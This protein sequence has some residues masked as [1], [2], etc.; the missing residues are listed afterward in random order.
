MSR[1]L[2][3][4]IIPV[5][6]EEPN[7]NNCLL[8]LQRLKSE[9]LHNKYEFEYIFTDNNS[10]DGSRQTLHEACM[11]DPSVKYIRF[12]TNVGYQLSILTGYINANGAAMLQ[13]DC[14]MQDPIE[15]AAEFIQL[16]S[17]GY[18]VVYGVRSS[19]REGTVITHCRRAFYRVLNVLS[20]VQIPIDAG[21]FRLLDREVCQRLKY[22]KD[23]DP[24]IRGIIASFGYRQVGVP[25][26]R[27]ARREGTSK[28]PL[29][30]LYKL[31]MHGLINH[32]LV[33]LRL[34]T[35]CGAAFGFIAI[36]VACLYLIARILYGEAWPAGFTTLVLLLLFQFS[37]MSL[38]F[39]ILGEYIGRM[40]RCLKPSQFVICEEAVNIEKE[41]IK[42]PL[43]SEL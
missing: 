27:L 42:L 22:I 5:L 32:S 8:K 33:P 29:K 18:K 21:D 14:D 24:Y 7:I 35:L 2:I 28:F 39:G 9:L 17:E 26:D 3:S 20:D 4:I 34:A 16:W 6:N 36:L 13:Y 25:Y 38:F 23:P 1:Q 31:G 19:R 12:S 11:R 10:S 43:H 40:Y 15:V 30:Q 37:M 41:K